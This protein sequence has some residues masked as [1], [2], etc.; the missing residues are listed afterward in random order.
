MS[1]RSLVK[2]PPGHAFT[3]KTVVAGMVALLG[4]YDKKREMQLGGMN[5]IAWDWN[6]RASVALVLDGSLAGQVSVLIE[7]SNTQIFDVLNSWLSTDSVKTEPG[8]KYRNFGSNTESN[9]AWVEIM[10]HTSKWNHEKVVAGLIVF[11]GASARTNTIKD[12]T[13][14]VTSFADDS[15]ASGLCL[16]I[17]SPIETI[18][19]DANTS[20]TSV[21]IRPGRNDIVRLINAWRYGS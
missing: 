6:N 7:K 8:A 18:N 1:N 21:R 15:I 12:N 17:V 2:F 13:H 5:S 20:Y 11:L 4:N 14:I 3:P 9:G 10:L 16:Q 19:N